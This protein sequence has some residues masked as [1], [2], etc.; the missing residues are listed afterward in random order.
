MTMATMLDVTGP[1]PGGVAYDKGDASGPYNLDLY[2][3][4][5]IHTVLKTA[6]CSY[7]WCG[8]KRPHFAALE[9]RDPRPPV[10]TRDEW[11]KALAGPCFGAYP[12]MRKW[13]GVKWPADKD[14]DID[15]FF[16]GSMRADKGGQS[17]YYRHRRQ[18][19]DEARAM[20]DRY[21]VVIHEGRNLTFEEYRDAMLRSKVALVPWGWGEL[22]YRLYEAW[23]AGC[24][25]VMRPMPWLTDE[26]PRSTW[27]TRLIEHDAFCSVMTKEDLEMAVVWRSQCNYTREFHR[28]LAV[29][30]A[31][32]TML[33]D[34]KKEALGR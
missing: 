27:H 6:V 16:A 33:A 8:E 3:D 24:V 10:L 21:N 17:P 12:H 2:R 14:R 31:D 29:W 23:H 11:S 7:D 9:G 25:P 22:S 18:M 28:D 26:P 19:L 20:A 4:P 30:L 34:W 15:I 1:L 32:G 13:L 5:A